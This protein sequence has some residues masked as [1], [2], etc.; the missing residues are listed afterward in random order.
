LKNLQI[1]PSKRSK[2]W[3]GIDSAS[4]QSGN[5]PFD[6]D[7]MGDGIMSMSPAGGGFFIRS[8]DTS[9]NSGMDKGK[10]EDQ[11]VVPVTNLVEVW[12]ETSDGYL[13]EYSILAGLTTMKELYHHNH[14]DYK[15]PMPIR[16][17]RD[18][19]VGSFWGRSY[20]DMMIPFNNEIELALSS[21]FEAVADFDL[22]GLQLW[23][24]TLGNPTL[25]ERG[26]DG[27]KRIRYEPDYTCPEIKIENVEP[28]KMT[29]PQLQAIQLA[30]TLLDKLANQPAE[31]MSGE[32]PG[33]RMDSAAG[34]SFLYETSGIPLSPVAKSIAD[35]V[36]GVYRSL[37]R[38]LK[39]LW[40]D[41]KVVNVSS[42]D[43]SLAGIVL[44]ADEGT[45]SLS[46]NAIPMPEE[47]TIKVA[48]EVPVSKAKE[49]AELKEALKEQRITL[50]EFNW[51]VRKR[52][53]NIPV[54]DEIGWQNYRRA[55]LNNIILFGDGE[56]PGQI[57]INPND[58]ARVHIQVMQAF[59]ARPE[60]FAASVK[61]RDAF[62]AAMEERKAQMG[63]F[64]D[65]LPY[66]EEQAEAMLG[67]GQPPQA[68][69]PMQ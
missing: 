43:D 38:Q 19:T 31:M 3:K 46:K 61:V 50:D 39:D 69:I 53:L 34:L 27:I 28:S 58:L 23:P 54:G 47:V 17:I 5:L 6:T 62:N 25:A 32:V 20:V 30:E 15:Y 13:A 9:K 68:G 10:K 66:P 26:Q 65:Q 64:P 57:I 1:T 49:E 48:S 21:M 51:T 29:G 52:G 7:T 59:M 56:M 12:T 55:M 36:A 35:A 33:K 18:V 42:L 45:L 60:F 40:T 2:D 24:T 4:I 41:Q 16:V 22:Y 8:V 44:D 14:T 37:L 63:V 11:T 67:Q